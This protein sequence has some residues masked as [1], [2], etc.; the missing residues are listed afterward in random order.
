MYAYRKLTKGTDAVASLN[1]C[2][3]FSFSNIAVFEFL[4]AGQALDKGLHTG[5][6]RFK[7]I[8]RATIHFDFA[9]FHENDSV[10]HVSREIHFMGH[11]HHGHAFFGQLDNDVQYVFHQLGVQRRGWCIEKND[12]G[13]HG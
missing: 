4:G 1:T 10:G 6:I 13:I 2:N 11:D 9:V 12:F 7:N 3:G 8:V 5:I